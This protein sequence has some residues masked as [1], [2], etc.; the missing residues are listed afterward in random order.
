MGGKMRPLS[1]HTSANMPISPPETVAIPTFG[2]PGGKA[3]QPAEQD[4]G[5]EQVVEGVDPHDVGTAEKGVEYPVASRDGPGMG[6][7]HAAG[8]F[9]APDLER[10]DGLAF[11]AAREHAAAKAS[12]SR[13]VSMKR[14][15]TCVAS[16]STR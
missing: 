4:G 11:S 7:R 12:G 1:K 13:M 10:D 15:I 5:F 2:E 16:S 9:R 8:E 6:G 3:A 14:A